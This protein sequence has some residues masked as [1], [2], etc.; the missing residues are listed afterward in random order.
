MKGVLK[1]I[2]ALVLIMVLSIQLMP[3]SAFAASGD[4]VT[5]VF[6]NEDFLNAAKTAYENG[7][8]TEQD[9][10]NVLSAIVARIGIKG[11]NKIVAVGTNLCDYYINSL[12]WTTIV[13]LGTGAVGAIIGAIPGLPAAAAAIIASVAGGVGAGLLSAENGVIIR[14]RM[15]D[16]SGGVGA[17]RYNYEFVSIRE[18]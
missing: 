6:T 18:Q 15:N 1:R 8:I 7:D 13:T 17:P 9:Y 12:L 16:I 11:E 4:D 3:M 2:G 14:I 5:L 10:K